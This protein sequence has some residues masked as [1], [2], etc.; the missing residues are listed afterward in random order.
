MPGTYRFPP[1]Q[2]PLSRLLSAVVLVLIFSLAFLVGT[3]VFLAVLGLLAILLMAVYLRFWW[4]RRRW[5]KSHTPRTD[6]S[7]VTLEGE[8][9]V[10]KTEESRR[11][12]RD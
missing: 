10:S 6:R 12:D 2:G 5:T 11:D 9:T 8:Y 1:N 4:L 7:G 3:F